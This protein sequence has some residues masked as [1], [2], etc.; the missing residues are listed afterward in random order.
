[1]ERIMS[2]KTV[3]TIRLRRP[4]HTSGGFAG[5]IT[6]MP[7]VDELKPERVQEWLKTWPLWQLAGKGRMIQRTRVFP[8]CEAAAHYSEFVA[9]LARALSLP[10]TVEITGKQV[11]L[12]LY[13][14]QTGSRL[15]P[16]TPAVLD[17][18]TELG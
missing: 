7:G 18:A 17:F 6:G 10:V 11:R 13:A 15:A 5:L 4:P 14:G 1:M 2:Q 8:D 16:L 9:G 3:V 12:S